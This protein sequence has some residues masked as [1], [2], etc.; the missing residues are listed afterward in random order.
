MV[1]ITARTIMETEHI[2]YVWYGTDKTNNGSLKTMN[3]KD[4]GLSRWG[5]VFLSFLVKYCIFIPL[6]HKLIFYL[7]SSQYTFPLGYL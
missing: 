1:S 7:V 6:I 2:S 3:L 5:N 4:R